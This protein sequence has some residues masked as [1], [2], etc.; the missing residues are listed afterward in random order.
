MSDTINSGRGYYELEELS[1]SKAYDWI[2]RNLL[3]VGSLKTVYMV[4]E[5]LGECQGREVW[6]S[7]FLDYIRHND[8][9]VQEGA[10]LKMII[11]TRPTRDITRDLR[12]FPAIEVMSRITKPDVGEFICRSVEAMAGIKDGYINE[13]LKDEII[14]TLRN[15]ANGLYRTQA[16]DRAGPYRAGPLFGLGLT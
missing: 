14:S 13:A 15:Y 11:T 1:Y 3:R 6:L 7:E 2:L 9:A 10:K 5:G 12:R 8:L 16:W 4:I